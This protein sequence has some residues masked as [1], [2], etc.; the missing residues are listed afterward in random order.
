MNKPLWNIFQIC[1]Y[2]K[3]V[4]KKEA[5][6]EICNRIGGE[7]SKTGC[8]GEEMDVFRLDELV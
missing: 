2:R 1:K 8:E 4:L 7:C 6:V 5:M 3:G